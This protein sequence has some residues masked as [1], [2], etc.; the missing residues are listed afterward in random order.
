MKKIANGSV[1]PLI[2]ALGIGGPQVVLA[3]DADG[4]GFVLEEILVTAQRR[5]Q[6][7]Q[8]VAN[9]I[10]ALSGADLDALGK[11]GFEDYISGVGGVGFTR[12]GNGSVKIG[13]RG[14]SAVAQ[15]QYAF[16]STVSTTGLYLDDVAIQGAGALPDLNLY[17]LQRIEVLKGPQGTL[18]GEGAMGGAIKVITNKPELSG[19]A[20]KA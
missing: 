17:D 14:V 8:D 19:F 3:Q 12:N 16:A 20:A 13:L 15:D 1:A 10:T 6:N 5:T 11:V 4:S 7:I 9:S 18:Y 2:C